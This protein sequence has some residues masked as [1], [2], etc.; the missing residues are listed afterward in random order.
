MSG[1]NMVRE[2]AAPFQGKTEKKRYVRPKGLVFHA[3]PEQA[4]KL[5][6]ALQQESDSVASRA[7]AQV[8]K[9]E[10]WGRA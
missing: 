8:I 9:D 5:K 2:T 4:E 6:E 3:N 7:I 10:E 1:K